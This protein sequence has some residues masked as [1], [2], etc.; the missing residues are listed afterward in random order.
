MD[1]HLDGHLDGVWTGK[2]ITD[3]GEDKKEKE[4]LGLAAVALLCHLAET[5]EP[6]PG[7][8]RRCTSIPLYL[9]L[10]QAEAAPD[11]DRSPAH[12]YVSILCTSIFYRQR[13]SFRVAA[14]RR[15]L[16]SEWLPPL[17]GRPIDAT[18]LP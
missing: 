12:R 15:P 10:S 11:P 8:P 13:R 6:Q 5:I 1:G 7:P 16:A 18:R 4:M 9:S 14:H 3:G 17:S 2:K